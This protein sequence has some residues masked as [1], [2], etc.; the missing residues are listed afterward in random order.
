[1]KEYYKYRSKST[2]EGDSSNINDRNLGEL[3]SITRNVLKK[4]FEV[5][6][7]ECGINPN[8]TW[9]ELKSKEISILT[10]IVNSKQHIF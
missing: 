5:C 6:H 9:K 1:M 2:H 7:I 10:S 4:F 8:L 3:E